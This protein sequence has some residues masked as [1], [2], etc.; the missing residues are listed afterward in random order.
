MN[1]S[2]SVNIQRTI[3]YI[4][5]ISLVAL[6][7]TPFLM[8]IVSATRSGGDIIKGFKLVI[9]NQFLPN[10]NA[11]S[12]YVDVFRGMMNSAIVAVSATVVTAYFSTLT[13]YGFEFYDFKGKNFLF[14]FILLMMMVPAQLGLIGFY[15][16]M[17]RFK[18]IDTYFP[19]IVPSIANI[20]G[21]FFIRQ[22]MA[23]TIHVALI[24][25]ARIDGASEI[26]IF[27]KIVFRLSS[28]AVATITIMAFIGSWNDYM[29]P[30][31][32]I[33]SPAKKTLPVMVGA[34]RGARVIQQNLGAIYAA[35]AVSV[36]PILVVFVIFSKYII[37]G[38]SSGSVK[39]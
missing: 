16:L 22:Y 9:G 29:R 8:M 10:F 18:L 34:L 26:G 3:I 36:I 27:H 33:L 20:F 6:C 5:L 23:S 31:L 30:L 12:A 2:V 39:G 32:M 25:A 11:L 4:F 38:I 15:D 7:L 21:V 35:V 17:L 1:K 19:L 13:A 24:E 37:S 28:P 14:A